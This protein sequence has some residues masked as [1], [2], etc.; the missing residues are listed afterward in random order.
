M[1]SLKSF[2]Y[3]C[4]FALP[5]FLLIFVPSVL[6]VGK[7]DRV[8]GKPIE[9]GT[10]SGTPKQAQN[11]L[12]DTKLKACQAKE[13]SIKNRSTHLLQLATTM[14]KN[15][16]AIAGRVKDYYTTKVL[17]GRSVANYDTLVANIATKK[18]AVETALTK[19]QNDASSFSCIDSDP[20]AQMT[21]YRKDMQNVIQ[22]LKDYRTSIKN[23]IVAVHSVTGATEKASP[24]PKP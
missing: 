16:D 6:A 2:K 11:R 23:L 20:K 22:A 21:Q 10:S 12:N 5:A 19:T 1:I 3:L 18:L 17:P 4:L 14:Q 13:N 7:P 8:I 9:V 15:F 24:S